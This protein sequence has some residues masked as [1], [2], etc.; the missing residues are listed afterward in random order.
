MSKPTGAIDIGDS[1]AG[2]D[3]HYA[4][5]K[6]GAS[7]SSTIKMYTIVQIPLAA[8]DLTT[9]GNLER[10]M[11]N[12]LTISTGDDSV[13]TK[14]SATNNIGMYEPL[15][16]SIDTYV[17]YKYPWR[18]SRNS[19]YGH[20]YSVVE[21]ELF[22]GDPLGH[23]SCVA[24]GFWNYM[25]A[26]KIPD[27]TDAPDSERYEAYQEATD[28]GEYQFVPQSFISAYEM[29]NGIASNLNLLTAMNSGCDGTGVMAC[30]WWGI[31]EPPS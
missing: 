14:I 18:L 25:S 20:K 5:S 22:H 31:V 28:T 2:L 29:R 11:G 12:T 10:C 3:L 19:R 13:S 4:L 7:K 16:D 27:S 30:P 21:F 1:Y 26:S 6:Y 17:S 24:H 8:M 9:T 15:S 23:G